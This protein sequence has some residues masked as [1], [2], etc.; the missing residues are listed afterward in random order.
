[1]EAIFQ[2]FRASLG[3]KGLR[4]GLNAA[5]GAVLAEGPRTELAV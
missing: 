2:A 3:G 1:V 5:T 4:F